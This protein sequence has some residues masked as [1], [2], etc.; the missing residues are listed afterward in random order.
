MQRRL[1]S[2]IVTPGLWRLIAS[3]VLLTLISNCCFAVV[4][5]TGD[6]SGNT[7]APEDDF[8]FANVGLRGVGSA[9]YLGNRWVITASHNSAGTV[10]FDGVGFDNVVDETHRLVNPADATQE[11]LSPSTDLILMRLREEPDLPAVRLSCRQTLIGTEV[12]MVGIGRDRNTNETF[13]RI[14]N[15]N[16]VVANEDSATESGFQTQDQRTKR[17]GTNLVNLVDV[18]ADSGSGDVLSFSTLF[19]E[20]IPADDLAQGVRGDSGGAAFQKNQGVWELVGVMHAIKLENRQPGGINTAVFGNETFVADMFIY[21]DQIREIVDF[22]TLPGDIDLDGEYTATDLDLMLEYIAHPN[23]NSCHYDLD[24]DSAVRDS[25]FDQLLANAGTLLGDTDL[26]GEVDFGDFL[27]LAW[28]F[29]EPDKGWAGGDFDG[30]GET[31]FL[32]FLTLANAFG[33][34]FQ[35]PRSSAALAAIPE[36]ASFYPLLL[37]LVFLLARRHRR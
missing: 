5:N 29:G 20:L 30:D 2:T 7:V 34:E 14:D 12:V 25:D 35:P 11:D 22:G 8:G 31:S 19:D 23:Y 18:S 13:W 1:D 9:V 10:F 3:F 24:G 17:W 37:G 32:D 36:P 15:N 16:W 4:I 27:Q 26:N 33:D 28:A 21:G 6:G